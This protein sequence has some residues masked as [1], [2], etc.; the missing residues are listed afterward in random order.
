MQIGPR[1]KLPRP[2]K[3]LVPRTLL[4]RSLLIILLPMVI[5]QAVAL[6]IFY[7]SHLD[8]LSRRLSASVAGEIAYTVDMLERMPPDWTGP[9]RCSRRASSSKWRSGWSG[10]RCWCRASGST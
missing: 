4:S 9:G 5:L 7:G 10:A 1:V 6:R 2:M 3:R 8:L